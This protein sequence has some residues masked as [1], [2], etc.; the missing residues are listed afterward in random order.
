MELFRLLKKAC[1]FVI[2][3]SIVIIGIVLLP[4]PGP[5][6]LVIAGGLLILSREF[7]WAERHLMIIKN[8]LKKMM[9]PS[10][11]KHDEKR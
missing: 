4:L 10:K 5:G 9:N 11:S 7:D 1:V 6:L 2:G 8:K 3:M